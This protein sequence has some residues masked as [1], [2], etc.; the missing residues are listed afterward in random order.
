MTNESI[1]ATP[2]SAI[3]SSPVK[4]MRSTTTSRIFSV[5]ALVGVAAMVF[6]P[7]WGSPST[8]RKMVEL[9][10]FVALAQMWN[11]L[12]GF[13]GVVSVGQQAFVGLGAYSMVVLVNNL[14]ANLYL[15]VLLGA[16]AVALISIPMGLIAFRLRGS[17]FAIGTWVLAEVAS[18]VMVNNTSVGAGSGASIKVTGYNLASRQKTVYWLALLVGIGSIIVTYALLRSRIGLQMQAIRDNE[19]G[20]RSLGANVYRTRFIVWVLAAFITAMAGANYYLSAIRVQP[21]S[22]FS[23]VNWTAPIIFMVVIGGIGTIE[24]PIIGALLYYFFRDRFIDQVTWY[25]ITLGIIAVIVA[26]RIQGGIWGAIRRLGVDLFP[27][28]RRLLD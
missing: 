3:R 7:S 17:Y 5:V 14:H 21:T 28:S 20:A 4:V 6:L 10:T 16:I 19:A 27:V 9:L 26:L 25:S 2:P 23:V 12:A 15:S 13:A 8:M 22:S 1:V 24:G 11:L 18:L